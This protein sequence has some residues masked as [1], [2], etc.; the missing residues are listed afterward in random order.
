MQWKWGVKGQIFDFFDPAQTSVGE[1]I[2]KLTFA[3]IENDLVQSHALTLVDTYGVGRSKRN[4]SPVALG[5]NFG[6]IPT[7]F[8][9]K[10]W[11]TPWYV[12]QKGVAFVIVKLDNHTIRQ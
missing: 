8:G 11:N 4:H 6:V 5:L 3:N 9:W 12:V 7:T 1:S 10:N 2:G